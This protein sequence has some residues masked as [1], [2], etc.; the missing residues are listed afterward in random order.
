VMQGLATLK[1]FNRSQY[2]V[3]TIGRIAEQFREAAMK[4]LRVA[5]LSAFALELLATVSVAIIAVEIGL[6]LLAGGIGFEQALFLLILAPEFYQPLRTL[7]THFHS[8]T[9]GKA[10]ADRLFGILEARPVTSNGVGD[11]VVPGAEAAKL[12][13]D[14][15]RQRT[16]DSDFVGCF[17]GGHEIRFENVNFA[18]GER[19][20]LKNVTLE[21]APGEHLGIVGPSGSGKS[22]LAALMLRF[23]QPT[24]GSITV[25]GV[26][27]QTLGL[28]Q[29]RAQIAWVGQNPHLFVDTIEENIRMGKRDVPLEA[30]IGAAKK[31]QAHEF[32]ARLPEG[33]QT[34]VGERGANLSGGQAQRIGL[35]RAF[36]R[37]SPILVLDEATAQL[38][39]ST[40][41][42]ITATLEAI[43][44]KTLILI[45]H[46]LRTIRKADRIIVLDKG[47][48]AEQGTHEVLMAMGGVY[49][50]L[51]EQDDALEFN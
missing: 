24:E 43:Q 46:R 6:R 31:A 28:A 13:P 11:E 19:G 1:L 38:D 36:L 33:Y 20:A 4:V 26:D 27:L 44:G 18:Y 30:V 15:K 10:A 40:E 39:R 3:I 37:D 29:W 47:E 17:G 32:I 51:V 2:Q 49:R 16:V 41:A 7:G 42:A 5:F 25:G 12:K 45:A 21:I 9:E 8:G 14:S 23:V 35:A 48:V 22:T 34:M 50:R